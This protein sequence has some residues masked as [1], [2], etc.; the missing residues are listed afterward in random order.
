LLHAEGVTETESLSNEHRKTVF[1]TF[2]VIPAGESHTVRFTYRP[3]AVDA[4]AYRL[5]VQKQAGTDAVP[6]T[7]RLVLPPDAGVLSAAPK[8]ESHEG[9]VLSFDLSLRR[10]RRVQVKL[11]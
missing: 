6:L 4:D 7:V 8:P 11:R 2:M 10:D 9:Q 1:T 3:P 5:L